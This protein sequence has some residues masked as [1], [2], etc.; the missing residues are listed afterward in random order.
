MQLNITG[1]HLELTE[2]LQEYVSTKFER[3]E[4]HVDNITNVQVV[5]K[6]EKERQIAEA[7]LHVAGADLHANA[8]ADDMYASID[9]LTDKID[10]QL[11]K[12]KE[13]AQARKQGATAR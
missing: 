8:E 6:L 3:L 10:R 11:I 7:T 13:K 4:R 1:Q 12:H 9:M 5:L 2:A